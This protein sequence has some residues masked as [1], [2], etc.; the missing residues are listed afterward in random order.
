MIARRIVLASLFAAG[1]GLAAVGPAAAQPYPNHP[2]RMIVPFPP[3]GPIDTMARLTA[4]QLTMRLGQQTVVENR[5]GA[6]STIGQKVVAAA[7]PDGYTLMFGS[8]G[9]LGVAPALYPNL[10]LE[11][12][13]MYAPV[14]SVALLPHVMVVPNSVPAKTVKEFVAYA[15]ANPGKLNYGAGLGTPP[16]LLSTLFKVKAGIDVVF[17]PY[18]GA[19]ASITDM[20]GGRTQYTIDGLVSLYPLIKDGKLRALGIARGERWPALPDVPTLPE[21]GFPDFVIDAW[22]GVVAPAGTPP[23]IV[24]KLNRAINDGLKSPEMKTGLERFSAIAKPGSP[25]DFTAFM[26]SELPKWA[27]LV[28]LSGATAN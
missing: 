8:S 7:D 10:H 24:A 1:I 2:I 27:G 12:L 15:K 14:A 4:Q 9:S 13:K 16:H 21:S 22:T 26:Q 11:P 3:G 20:L 19:A 25:Q 6:G 23:D 17:I 18:K 5:P 28:K